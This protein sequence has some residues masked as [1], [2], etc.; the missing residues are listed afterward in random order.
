MYWELLHMMA[1]RAWN[2]Q[3]YSADQFHEYYK[4]RFLGADDVRLPNGRTLTIPRSSADLTTEEFS[5]YLDRVQADAAER[6]V[7]LA[8]LAA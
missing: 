2:G 7:Y 1:A 5:E 8:D 6:G 4:S 3:H